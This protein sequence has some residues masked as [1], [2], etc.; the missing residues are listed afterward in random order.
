MSGDATGLAELVLVWSG[1]EP[2]RA[3]SVLEGCVSCWSRRLRV[4]PGFSSRSFASN[5]T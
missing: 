2:E 3:L 4:H 5:Y 1:S